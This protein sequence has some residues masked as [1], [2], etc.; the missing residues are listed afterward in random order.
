M[1]DDV[2]KGVTFVDGHGVR[3]TITGFQYNTCGTSRKYNDKT[4]WMATYV[5]W[6]LKVSNMICV[7]FSLLP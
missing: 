4:A 6:E 7:I 1:K 2:R 5:A 3:Y